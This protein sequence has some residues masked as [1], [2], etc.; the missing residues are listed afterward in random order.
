M[1]KLIL[2]L[3]CSIAIGC[4]S[5]AQE[6]QTGKKFPLTKTEAEWKAQLTELEF[7]VMRNG[8]T[9]RPFTSE[10]NDHKKTG[11][12]ACKACGTA[13]FK[14]EHKYDS[15]SG[16]PSFDRAIEGNVGYSVDYDIGYARME[17]HC[18]NCGGHLGH[19]FD[20]GPMETTGKRHCVNGV[21]LIFIPK[22]IE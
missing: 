10:F 2:I 9:E 11:I 20:D 4:N 21:A 17:E 22:T 18:A 3:L 5:K 15:K 14:S 12:F 16:W 6:T 8:G 7:H 19:V 1:Q 13:L